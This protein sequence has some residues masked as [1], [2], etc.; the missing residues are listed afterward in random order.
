MG[1]KNSM[2]KKDY[3][4]ISFNTQTLAPEMRSKKNL[5]KNYNNS[6]NIK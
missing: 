5:E 4:F 2:G 1:G 6:N 3:P